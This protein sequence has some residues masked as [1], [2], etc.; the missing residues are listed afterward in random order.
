MLSVW[1]HNGRKLLDG[2]AA[3][4]QNYFTRTGKPF[5]ERWHLRRN[6]IH[7]KFVGYL[8]PNFCFPSMRARW[9]SNH[10]IFFQKFP[11]SSKL[12]KNKSP[13]HSAALRSAASGDIAL[14]AC[15]VAERCPT[16]HPNFQK[17]FTSGADNIGAAAVPA[18]KRDKCMSRRSGQN[19]K[20]RVGKRADGTKYF[21]F[22]YWIDVAGPGRTATQDRSRWAC[23]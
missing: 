19:P 22:Q 21:F 12:T 17:E 3:I 16:V 2:F 10:S 23:R 1:Q 13:A 6:T 4:Y 9:R 20:V 11:R 8:C 7:F 15:A 14:D 5:P 18:R